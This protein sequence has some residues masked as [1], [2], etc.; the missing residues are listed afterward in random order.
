MLARTKFSYFKHAQI[1]EFY[2]LR[3]LNSSKVAD[4]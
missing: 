4:T 3:I 1:G 2:F